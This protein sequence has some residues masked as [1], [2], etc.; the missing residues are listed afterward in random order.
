MLE[1][2]IFRIIKYQKDHQRTCKIKITILISFFRSKYPSKKQDQFAQ[3]TQWVPINKP[4]SHAIPI[5]SPDEEEPNKKS[6][7]E[8]NSANEDTK[9]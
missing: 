9:P 7:L 3:K 4:R 1:S 2:I 8:Q 5:I 6:E